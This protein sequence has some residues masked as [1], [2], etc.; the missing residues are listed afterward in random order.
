MNAAT[1]LLVRDRANHCCE[2]CHLPQAAAPFL[3]F[4]IEHIEAQQHITDDS[5]D[6]LAL[7]CPDCN[8]RKGTNLVTL[9]PATRVLVRLFHPRRDIWN[10][11]FEYRG[12]IL[13]WLTQAG[14]ATIRLLQINT[15]ERIEMRAELQNCGDM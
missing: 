15:V 2:Y 10:H 13:I 5:L 12:A 7:A 6:N 4:H 11:H 8:R 9:I 14:E 3:T 1:R